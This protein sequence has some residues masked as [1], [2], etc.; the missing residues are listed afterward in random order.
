VRAITERLVFGMTA[1]AETHSR[2]SSKP[3]FLAF[4][5]RKFEITFD[6]K[7]AIVK[8]RHFGSSHEIP[9]DV[10]ANQFTPRYAYKIAKDEV[11]FKERALPELKLSEGKSNFTRA[12]VLVRLEALCGMLA[13]ASKRN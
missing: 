11:E 7:R 4:L 10:V 9:P 1:A 5:I 6:A 13:S 2:P 8:Y 12:R 3:K